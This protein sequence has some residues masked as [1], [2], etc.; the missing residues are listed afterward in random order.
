MSALLITDK[1]I[2]LLAQSLGIG[3]DKSFYVFVN[4]KLASINKI[5]SIYG[6]D[7]PRH[8]YVTYGIF[9]IASKNE[10]DIE[11]L[12]QMYREEGIKKGI[13]GQKFLSVAGYR[14]MKDGLPVG[15]KYNVDVNKKESLSFPKELLEGPPHSIFFSKERCFE[16]FRKLI[17]YAAQIVLIRGSW[18]GYSNKDKIKTIIYGKNN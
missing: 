9:Y 18:G 13:T 7:E 6:E 5:V 14:I 8:P 2:L 10:N 11:E 12:I 15:A 4:G 1:Q 17:R 16:V 3:I